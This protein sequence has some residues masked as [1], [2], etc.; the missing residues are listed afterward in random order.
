MQND[1]KPLTITKLIVENFK[2]IRVAEIEP[3]G[4]LVNIGG[5]NAQGKSSALD[6]IMAALCGAKAVPA[7]PIHEGEKSARVTVEI[8]DEGKVEIVVTLT[9]TDAG[10]KLKV[11]R[12]DGG[13]ISKPQ[14]YLDA[15]T[16]GGFS[17]DPL[18]FAR[19]KPADQRET[20]MRLAGLDFD[21]IDGR[22][23]AAFDDR[24]L[25]NRQLKEVAA[26]LKASTFDAS[27]PASEVSVAEISAELEQAQAAETEFT[28]KEA[29]A[30]ATKQRI[31]NGKAMIADINEQIVALEKKRE[32]ATRLLVDLEQQLEREIEDA[33]SVEEYD[34]DEIRARLADV[35][36]VNAAVRANAEHK[37]LKQ[38]VKGLEAEAESLTK[39]IEKCDE[40]KRAALGA[41]D[42]PVDGLGI[43]DEGV[44]FNGLPLAQASQAERIRVSTA[45]ALAMR[46]RLRVVFIRDGS[47]LDSQARQQVRE[48]AEKAG[49][50]VWMETVGV[51]ND[52]EIVFEDGTAE[53]RVPM[54]GSA[55][56]LSSPL[57][58]HKAKVL[59]ES[60]PRKRSVTV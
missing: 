21:A 1:S 41:A 28:R 13:V 48:M 34:L 60:K 8:G 27:A 54:V 18:E 24:T 42:L 53:A 39:A 3:H 57:E 55:Y 38:R 26:Q 29:Q 2:R 14:S 43:D 33:Q 10:P 56:G 6:A 15:L 31:D 5:N 59:K 12:A 47:L 17:F 23:K 46:P 44:T 36:R 32:E 40:E 45:M 51:S 19:A 25:V 16:G 58:A 49:A 22:R 52:T 35:E 4:A 37:K 20:L 7:K 50:Q 11:A 9:V 30:K